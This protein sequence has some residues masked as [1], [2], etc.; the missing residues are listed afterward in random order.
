MTA[1]TELFLADGFDGAS[2]D[3][4][5]ARAGVPKSTLYKRFPDKKALLR[6]VLKER[7]SVWASVS[8]QK[9]W[10]LTE[11]LEQRLKLYATWMISWAT[12][13]EV[14][15]FARLATSAWNGSDETVSRLDAIGYTRR[16]EQ[17]AQEIREFGPR[18]GI[19]AAEPMRVATAFMAM[20]A[21]WL[22]LKG[23]AVEIPTAEAEAFARTAV[24]LLLHG[25][26]A[27]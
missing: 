10:M 13:A 8:S 1:A 27:W 15:A 5:G 14:R 7:V 2:M 26:S 24:D 4:I 19:V 22:E 18:D 21:G 20:I 12:S 9:N 3:A 6:A 17:I 23:E 11:T 16:A 25:K